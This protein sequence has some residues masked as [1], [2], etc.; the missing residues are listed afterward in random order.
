MSQ[1]CDSIVVMRRL[2]SRDVLV[3]LR[4][5]DGMTVGSGCDHRLNA[6]RK[7]GISLIFA[8]FACAW[9]ENK[10]STVAKGRSA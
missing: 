9:S 2:M 6:L 3:L 7:A 10:V 5:F 4:S 8:V 1:R